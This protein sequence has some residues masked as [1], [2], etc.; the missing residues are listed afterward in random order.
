MSFGL[1]GQAAPPGRQSQRASLLS[2]LSLSFGGSKDSMKTM[3]ILPPRYE[4][5]TTT[6]LDYNKFTG[7]NF[8]FKGGGACFQSD[9]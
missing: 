1:R 2:N 7:M 8:F 9:L 5:D 3:L 6:G 4:F